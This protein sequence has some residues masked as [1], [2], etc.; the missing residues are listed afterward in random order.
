PLPRILSLSRSKTNRLKSFGIWQIRPGRDAGG[1]R[2]QHVRPGPVQRPSPPVWQLPG[3][4]VY[5]P[6]PEPTGIR[7]MT[8]QPN[9][10]GSILR[11]G[12]LVVAIMAGLSAAVP[13]IWLWRPAQANPVAVAQQS[14]ERPTRPNTDTIVLPPETVRTLG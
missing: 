9:S 1:G 10:W 13:V 5:P 6:A 4:S 11:R 12:A 8:L 14:D 3:G 2:R 7:T